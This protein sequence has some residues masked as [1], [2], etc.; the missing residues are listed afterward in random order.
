MDQMLFFSGHRTPWGQ[1]VTPWAA[2]YCEGET[3]LYQSQLPCP[4]L[5]AVTPAPTLHTRIGSGS[6]SFPWGSMRPPHLCS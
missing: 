5:Q 1:A 6:C 2:S 3:F 4:Y